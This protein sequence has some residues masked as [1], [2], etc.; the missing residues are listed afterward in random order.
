MIGRYADLVL[1]VVALPIFLLAGF[2][3]VGY[4]AVAAAWLSQRAVLAYAATRIQTADG[5]TAALRIIAGSFML[6]LWLLTIAI[7]L[8]GVLVS[9][10]AGLSAAVLAAALITA[11]LA[12][13]AL[14]RVS[15]TEEAAR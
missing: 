7:L 3:I 13:E 6:R 4:A 12:G 8:V 1:L 2:P 14:L 15:S 10:E 9:D 11:N 5:R